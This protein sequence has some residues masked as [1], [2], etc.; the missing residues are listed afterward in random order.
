[1]ALNRTLILQQNE[2]YQANDPPV[3]ENA[4]R[5]NLI[6]ET[7]IEDEALYEDENVLDDDIDYR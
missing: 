5:D 7:A 4:F 1:M 6:K 2:G 3:E